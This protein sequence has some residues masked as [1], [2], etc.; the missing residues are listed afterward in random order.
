M[1]SITWI[2]FSQ[3]FFILR[4]KEDHISLLHVYHHGIMPFN[5]WFAARFLGGC[6]SVFVPLLNTFVHIL[7][8][9]YYMVSAM[10]PSYSKAIAPWKKYLTTI[11]LVC[12]KLESKKYSFF[13]LVC[14]K[15]I[16]NCWIFHADS[17]LLYNG[18]R[19]PALLHWMWLPNRC[20]LLHR[21][22]GRPFYHSIFSVLLEELHFQDFRWQNHLMN[23]K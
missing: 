20:C 22:P 17:I 18:A 3:F 9:F 5:T 12:L 6:H 13:K 21:R 4:K 19:L 23:V 16:S 11:Q 1:V 15:N 10:G 2:H 8:Y 7:M 14:H